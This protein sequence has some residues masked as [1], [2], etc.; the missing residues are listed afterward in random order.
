MRMILA[1]LF[2]GAAFAAPQGYNYQLNINPAA[3]ND[4]NLEPLKSLEQFA[5]QQLQQ[6]QQQQQQLL[7]TQTVAIVNEAPQQVGLTQVPNAIN[8]QVLEQPLPQQTELDTVLT[9]QG[10]ETSIPAAVPQ[11]QVQELPSALQY[12][13]TE[14]QV[15]QP[16]PQVII[17]P[18][19]Q[20]KPHAPVSVPAPI[21]APVPTL[22]SAPAPA[23]PRPSHTYQQQPQQQGVQYNKEFFYLSAP[24]ED[25]DDTQ[26]FD[27]QFEQFKKNLRVIFIK[28]PEQNGIT[29]AALQLA[30][31]SVDAQTV[32]YV[33]TKKH[34]ANDLANKLQQIRTGAQNKPEVVFVKYRTPEEAAHAQRTI[35]AQYEHLDGPNHFNYEAPSASVLPFTGSTDVDPRK[36]KSTQ[37]KAEEVSATSNTQ[38][39][40]PNKT[41]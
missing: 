41:K 1:F 13:P 33:L 20:N 3:N 17:I 18:K 4:Y 24:Q 2:F 6:Q 34:D 9:N 5:Q 37:T 23:L 19:V 28:A 10:Y 31:Q 22:V 27:R 39:L 40:P 16:S 26:N 11:L 8:Y 38:Y 7:Q 15:A 29:K 30:Q 36:N 35:Q 12:K 32:I 25:F 21:P 14:A